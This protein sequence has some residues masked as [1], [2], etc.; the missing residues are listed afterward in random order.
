MPNLPESNGL[1][2]TRVWN[3]TRQNFR[4]CAILIPLRVLFVNVHREIN[5]MLSRTYPSRPKD[6]PGCITLFFC[7]SAIARRYGARYY[8]EEGFSG[9]DLYDTFG[10]GIQEKWC[11]LGQLGIAP[12]FNQEFA[13]HD[14][15]V[16]VK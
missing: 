13:D 2:K 1:H 14:V 5:T 8:D 16:R 4:P 3:N 12:I 15:E 9:H 11:V 6:F 7:P 10:D